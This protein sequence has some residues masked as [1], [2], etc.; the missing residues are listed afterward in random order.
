MNVSP[1]PEVPEHSPNESI[2]IA[3]TDTSPTNLDS[4]ID[5][6][7]RG[8]E[9]FRGDS[10]AYA[11]GEAP[12]GEDNLEMT[13]LLLREENARLKAERHRPPD[14][15]TMIA[16]MRRMAGEDGEDELSDEAWSLLSECFAI[17][18]ELSQ[19]CIE[20]RAAMSATQ[21]RLGRLAFAIQGANPDLP[22]PAVS[23]SGGSPE[24]E[25]ELVPP[26][27]QEADVEPLPVDGLSDSA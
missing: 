12:D 22:Y 1:Y 14:V 7:R 18:E 26:S 2:A 13:V 11:D 16:Q 6:F 15:G 19:A 5:R 27:P 25:L 10:D 9:R 4:R 8:F 23:H 20:I 24:R 21:A 3:P 17:R